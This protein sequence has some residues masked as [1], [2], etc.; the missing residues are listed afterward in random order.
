MNTLLSFFFKVI[1][2]HL[3]FWFP[4]M[5]ILKE[6]RIIKYDISEMY[7]KMRKILWVFIIYIL[8]II[9]D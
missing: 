3:D 6:K 7:Y 8:H 5:T 4:I 2:E 1:L 9:S